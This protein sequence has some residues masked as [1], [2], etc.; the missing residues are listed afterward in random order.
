MMKKQNVT[1][2]A[3]N[4][5]SIAAF[6]SLTSTEQAAGSLGVHPEAWRPIKFMNDQHFS[7]LVKANALD[8]NLARRIEVRPITCSQ[9]SYTH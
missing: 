7:A 2:E 1:I 8:D 5:T 9:L 3:S 4:E 6:E